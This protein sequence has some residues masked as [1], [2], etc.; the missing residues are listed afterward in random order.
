[1]EKAR[2][3]MDEVADMMRGNMTKIMERDGKLE[4]LEMKV[5]KLHVESQQ[6]LVGQSC[7]K[8]LTSSLYLLQKTTV[9]VKKRAI[10]E[11]MKLKLAIGGVV[12][13]V[14]IVVIII[15]AT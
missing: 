11:N 7:D 2:S 9:K 1:M 10:L 6:F 5:D 12:C 13:L 4:D 14:V 15:I 3:Q 8:Y